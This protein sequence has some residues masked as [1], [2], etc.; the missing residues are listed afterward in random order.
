MCDASL[1]ACGGPICKYNESPRAPGAAQY[2]SQA[3]SHR[4]PAQDGTSRYESALFGAT[5][6][7]G[8]PF[9]VK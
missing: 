8:L 5:A 1:F 6:L 4:S 3:R 9:R 2:T 7:K